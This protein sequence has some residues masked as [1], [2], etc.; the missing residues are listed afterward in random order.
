VTSFQLTPEN[1]TTTTDPSVPRLGAAPSAPAP[2]PGAAPP[3]LGRELYDDFV[4]RARAAHPEVA[5]GQFGADMQ[6]ALIND[7][8]VTIALQMG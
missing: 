2:I 8:P 1:P 6:V 4:A 3:A 5:T 7:G